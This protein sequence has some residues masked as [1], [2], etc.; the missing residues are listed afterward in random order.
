MMG[1]MN[2]VYGIPHCDTVK[3]ARA[4]LNAH[5]ISHQFHDLKK[6][7]VP[8]AALNRWL[9]HT[10]WEAL[11]NRRGTTWRQLDEVTRAAVTGTDSARVVLLAHASLIKRPIVE[12]DTASRITVGFDAN[13]WATF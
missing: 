6:Q 10:G 2:M 1:S 5:K 3:L 9:G 4:W 7:G 8:E 11:V 13:L 12:W